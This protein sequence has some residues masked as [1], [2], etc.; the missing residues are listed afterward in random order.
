MTID[1]NIPT[2]VNPELVRERARASF[3]VDKLST[4]LFA[5]E[6]KLKRRMELTAMIEV[7]TFEDDPNMKNVKADPRFTDPKPLAFMT[8]PERL[9]NV[10]RKI[11]ATREF[12]SEH[13]ADEIADVE[14][15]RH[16]QQ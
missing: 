4:F 15:M 2:G 16:V 13:C 11:V 3:N 7:S 1:T 12:V 9:E 5:G 6:K 14:M 8:R 10:A